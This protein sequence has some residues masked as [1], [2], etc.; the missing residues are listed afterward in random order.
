MPAVLPHPVVIEAPSEAVS[1]YVFDAVTT[2]EVSCDRWMGTAFYVGNGQFLT[3]RHIVQGALYCSIAGKRV[4][5]VSK[6][7]SAGEDWAL[8]SSDYRPPFRV[9]YTCDRMQP[10]GQYWSTGYAQGNPWLVTTRL[11]GSQMVEQ[12]TR[13]NRGVIIGGMSGGPVQDLDG[14]V[15]GLNS[16]SLVVGDDPL[17]TAGVVEVADTPLC[18][19]DPK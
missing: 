10:G 11:R 19:K 8:I 12:G 16:W 6:G 7:P 1:P 13:E 4:S 15:Y 2:V 14:V 5:V 18:R 17:P 3:A 9:V